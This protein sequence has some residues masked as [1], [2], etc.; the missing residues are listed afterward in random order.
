MDL[1]GQK[2]GLIQ[3]E[4]RLGYGGMG[5]VY[6]G[7]HEK[8]KRRVAVKSVKADRE[9]KKMTRVRFLREARA[10]SAL[11]HPNICRIYDYLE[12]DQFELLVLELIEGRN[13]KD[14]LKDKLT[15]AEKFRYAMQ[16]TSAL[17]AAHEQGIIH[18]DIKPENIMITD[19]GVLKILDFGISRVAFA[20]EK[21][22]LDGDAANATGDSSSSTKSQTRVGTLMGT[23]SYM[24]PEQARGEVA[25]A[26]SDM[27]ALGLLLQELFTGQRPYSADLNFN[28][29]LQKAAQGKSRPVKD[30]EEDLGRLL[31]RLKALVP[32]ARPS[33]RDTYE[34][35]AFLAG[36][37]MR[38]RKQ[39]V[40]FAF[41]VALLL[42]GV[43]MAWQASRIRQEAQR[44]NQEAARATR[45]AAAASTVSEFLVGL[46]EIMDPSQ[47]LG[48]KVTARELLDRGNER[49][50]QLS[51]QPL[52]QARI[53]STMGTLYL[54]LGLSDSAAPLLERALTSRRK[55]LGENNLDVADSLT[56]VARLY[57]V[58]DRFDQAL[59]LAEEAMSIRQK[60]LGPDC[61]PSAQERHVLS[62]IHWEFGD[63]AIAKQLAQEAL[64]I[65][66]RELPADHPDIGAILS[67]LGN[68]YDVTGNNR[69]AERV[70]LRAMDILE[71]SSNRAEL[72]Y[73][74]N[75]LAKIR[76][77]EG[78]YDQA[79][80]LY[81]RALALATDSLG[82]EHPRIGSLLNNIAVLYSN[83]GLD[84]EA[85]D[86]FTRAKDIWV[87]A[88]GQNH[89]T[90]ALAL[91]NIA[92]TYVDLGEY[93]QAIAIEYQAIA[94]QES[95]RDQD[96]GDLATHYLS[97]ARALTLLGDFE[98]ARAA[99]RHAFD[100]VAH[101]ESINFELVAVNM[102]F[103]A[104]E[105]MKIDRYEDA[106]SLYRNTLVLWDQ[107][108]DPPLDNK[109]HNLEELAK[110]MRATKREEEARVMDDQA[111]TLQEK[112]DQD[113]GA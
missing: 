104:K 8:L 2:V 32:E 30:V 88:Y 92:G 94:I 44:A 96:T 34:R 50:D 54:K 77:Q 103:L 99:Y 48:N 111:R 97:L 90:V 37:P 39:V 62:Q 33:A 74:I 19:K 85:L 28:T 65:R 80:E 27:Y 3:I 21:A 12:T 66:E 57:L 59:P 84:T 71:R 67:W 75:G 83:Q 5:E 47:D 18:R 68:I 4:G 26:A 79:D 95:I 16:L 108:K 63:H 23:L 113:T 64:A 76:S 13:L 10:L 89:S 107:V 20:E 29:L 40:T 72:I 81:R 22:A 35:L 7:F 49:L 52:E 15:R 38:R 110:I 41:V 14:I 43:V 1:T 17:A 69:E 100:I 55:H 105:F 6:A 53:M 70:L 24:S 11:D 98:A 36:A 106:E 73:A 9:A 112:I 93:R 56:A 60:I 51:G 82:P 25:T 91:G 102:E 45:S 42:F 78:Y 46:F 58:Q 31:K 61:L 101:A 109:I 87:K 86:Y